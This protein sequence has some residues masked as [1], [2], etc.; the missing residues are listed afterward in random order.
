MERGVAPYG[1]PPRRA[2]AAGFS[3]LSTSFTDALSRKER[4]TQKTR[5]TRG[6]AS[7]TT[8][9]TA[10]R[11]DTHTNGRSGGR[12]GFSG[13]PHGTWPSSTKPN[14]RKR[15]SKHVLS[16]VGGVGPETIAQALGDT[17]PFALVQPAGLTFAQTM[18][19][20]TC[21]ALGLMMV[22]ASLRPLLVVMHGAWCAV[23]PSRWRGSLDAKSDAAVSLASR[24]PFTDS[25]FGWIYK[26]LRTALLMVALAWTY[27]VIVP[28]SSEGVH[29]LFPPE[30]CVRVLRILFY[31]HALNSFRQRYLARFAGQLRVK[32]YGKSEPADLI[33][34]HVYDRETGVLVWSLTFL[35]ALDS[36]GLPL[37]WVVK[38]LGASTVVLGILA[39]VVLRDTVANYF[40]GLIVIAAGWFSPKEVVRVLLSGRREISG[41]VEHIGLLYTTLVNRAGKVAYIPNSAM[42]AHKVENLSRAPYREFREQLAIP[43]KDLK[44][45]PDIQEQIEAFLRSTAGADTMRGVSLAPRATL[46]GINS[47]AGGAVLEVVCYNDYRLLRQEGFTTMRLRHHMFL[48]IA[49]IFESLGVDFAIA[50]NGVT[51]SQGYQNVGDNGLEGYDGTAQATSGHKRENT[52]IDQLDDRAAVGLYAKTPWL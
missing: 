47:F 5:S 24:K 32:I 39:S 34:A 23:A 35:A 13:T 12:T 50:G 33:P 4:P 15:Q 2:N 3:T 37:Q 29:A 49:E 14:D 18:A 11:R 43:F 31:G 44:Y 22:V 36:L 41:R 51:G 28:I 17:I 9:A 19:Y 7:V 30:K 52:L 38:G 20:S 42:V 1:G 27:I 6:R 16:A 48:G 21:F 40:G 8:H 25:F 10:F 45:V 26:I 46:T